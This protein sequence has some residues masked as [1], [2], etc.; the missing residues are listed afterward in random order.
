[1]NV[2]R[3]TPSDCALAGATIRRIKP[4]QVTPEVV[5]RFLERPDH[6]FIA[7]IEDENPVGFALVY[8]LQR[9]DRLQP[10]LFLYEIGVA[11]ASRRRGV[12]SAMVEFLKST[13]RERNCFKVFVITSQANEAALRLYSSRFGDAARREESVVFTVL[14]RDSH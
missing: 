11:E 3:L 2:R 1:M 9:I 5:G 7:A 14:S 13:C 8:E 10:M 4:A 12:A 6:Y